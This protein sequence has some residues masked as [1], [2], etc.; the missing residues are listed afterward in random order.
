MNSRPPTRVIRYALETELS[1]LGAFGER[2][3]IKSDHGDNKKYQ[4]INLSK[5]ALTQIRTRKCDYE[6]RSGRIFKNWENSKAYLTRRVPEWKY[7]SFML[8]QSKV[9][10]Q[11]GQIT[12]PWCPIVFALGLGRDWQEK[13]PALTT[14]SMALWGIRVHSRYTRFR[15]HDHST[16][17]ESRLFPSLQFFVFG[18]FRIIFTR[19][20]LYVAKTRQKIEKIKRN[21]ALVL[22]SY[23]F[24]A[25]SLL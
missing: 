4:E 15:K 16:K 5:R 21:M 17:S 12:R 25:I 18:S 8:L 23:L 14:P 19:C 24:K 1:L 22:P 2:S 6:F 3:G 11:R 20:K 7:N 13:E 10:A 9:L